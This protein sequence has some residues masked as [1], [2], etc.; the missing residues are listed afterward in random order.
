MKKTIQTLLFGGILAVSLSAQTT[1]QEH[2]AARD[3][4]AKQV[5]GREA[6][7]NQEVHQERKANNGHLTGAERAQVARQ[8]AHATRSSRVR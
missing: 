5:Q 1:A 4:E 2:S 8:R 3:R 7:I 6:G